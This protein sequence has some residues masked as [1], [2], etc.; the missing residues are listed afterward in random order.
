MSE[1]EALMRRTPGLNRFLDGTLILGDAVM[2][3]ATEASS[4]RL[5]LDSMPALAGVAVAAWIAAGALLGDYSKTPDPDANPLSDAVGW[6]IVQAVVSAMVTWA[7]ALV[8]S[9]AGFSWLVSQY[10][11]DPVVVLEVPHDGEL[12]PQIEVSVALLVTMACWRGTAA[13]LRM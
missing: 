12:S 7:V 3:L 4:E 6:P 8:A 2:V 10:L 9:I 13:R 11:V 5:P 1:L